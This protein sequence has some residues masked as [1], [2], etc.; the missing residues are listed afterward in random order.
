M[1]QKCWPQPKNGNALS[2]LVILNHLLT[3]S[4][5]PCF[6]QRFGK[7]YHCTV[8]YRHYCVGLCIARYENDISC[9][10]WHI[11][12]FVCCSLASL[13]Y[14]GETSPTQPPNVT[15]PHLKC[16]IPRAKANIGS[17][18]VRI[19]IMALQLSERAIVA[20]AS[21]K[22]ERGQLVL[23]TG[24]WVKAFMFGVKGMIDIFVFHVC[25]SCVYVT[26]TKTFWRIVR[27]PYSREIICIR[28]GYVVNSVDNWRKLFHLVTLTEKTQPC[29]NLD[30]IIYF[31]R[32]IDRPE[33]YV[34]DTICRSSTAIE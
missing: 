19:S 7:W 22:V 9:H 4:L 5:W 2:S 6:L 30:R 27:S 21:D 18:V 14:H 24:M 15:Q 11:M 12:Y 10:I 26:T 17:F 20:S 33:S 25:I 28:C 3:W 1:I 13:R 16:K 31:C 34:T 8:T 23:L 29:L 32:S